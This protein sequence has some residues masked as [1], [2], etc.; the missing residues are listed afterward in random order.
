MSAFGP[1]RGVTEVP[2]SDFGLSGLFLI[3]G[4]TGAGK[5]TI[6]DAIS[7]A[8]YGNASGDNRTTDT[9]RSDYAKDDE[10][11]Y[12]ELSFSHHQK[13]YNIKRNPS[14]RRNKLRGTGTTEEKNN[15][16][17]TMPDGR[18]IC[19]YYPVTE[20]VIELLGIDWRQYK[21]IAMIAQ[22]EFLQLLNANSDERGVIFRKVFS[23]QVYDVIQKKLKEKSNQLK[24]QCEDIDKGILQYLNGILCKEDSVHYEA[25]TS[26]KAANSINQVE[27][28]MNL[29][30]TLIEKDQL[31]LADKKN[32]NKQLKQSIG[33]KAVEY[34][35]AEQINLKLINLNQAK[36]KY[37]QIMQN[38]EE[39]QL[40]EKKYIQAEKALY[41]VKPS[42]D[43]YLRLEKE[44]KILASD[45]ERG[46]A[47]ITQ[48]NENLLVLSQ[49]YEH[50]KES[51]PQIAQL[52]QEISR[53]E[54]ELLKYDSVIKEENRKSI[55]E[56]QIQKITLLMDR[57]ISQ[58][59]KLLEEQ[60]EKQEMMEKYS[61]SEKDLLICSNQLEV[62][63]NTITQNNKLMEDLRNI[64]TDYRLFHELQEEYLQAERNYK[65]TNSTYL[66]KE[67]LFL[68]E[69]AGI[70]ASTLEEGQPCPV[71]GSKD[72]PQKALLTVKAPS[73][74][75]LKTEKSKQ[76]KMH[77]NM[78][79]ASNRCESQ[80]TKIQLLQ[81]GIVEKAL[82]ILGIEI[83]SV[84]DEMQSLIFVTQDRLKETMV[85]SEELKKKYLQLQKDIENRKLSSERLL[86]IANELLGL[87]EK[88]SENT[89]VIQ[90]TKNELS[91]V[92]GTLFTIK[93][94]LK[95]S[96]KAEAEA[97]L[98]TIDAEC[99]KLQN[100]LTRAEA[101][102]RKCEYNLGNAN[103]VLVDNEKRYGI[104][105]IDFNMAKGHY[106]QKLTTYGFSDELD[107]RAVLISENALHNIKKNIDLFK[108][109]KETL[110][111]QIEQLKNETKDQARID[112]EKITQ[113][114]QKL[115][116]LNTDCEEQ[117]NMIYSRLTNN[118][119]IMHKV[120]EQNI[121]QQKVRQ[122]F[123]TI[124]E[125]SKTANGELSGKTKIAFEQYVQAFYF[126]KVIHE[127][128]KRFYHMSN[129]QY[130]LKRREDPSNLKSSS[131][132][133]LE[134]M[135]YYTGKS[136]SIKSLSGGESFK[137][138]LS[139]A[140]GLSDIIQSYAGGIEMNAMFVD[141]GFGSL[142]SDSLEQAIETL[143]DLT[144]GN[145][146][147]GIISH[148]NELK[149]RIDK[150]IL[151]EKSMEGS[152]LKLIK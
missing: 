29:L 5:T 100:D 102:F 117:I 48:L 128:N 99:K 71:C 139:L 109:D 66:G 101:S 119:D 116:Q 34:L 88:L 56:E 141:E 97:A 138:A 142:D 118:K 49:N 110:E 30:A 112:L 90:K 1:F 81:E 61:D 15:A 95:Y 12:V 84:K 39:M 120:E 40:E 122:E 77:N 114:Q 91:S 38:T 144:S 145:R 115:N 27:K 121:V 152:K 149:E 28:M 51:M 55:L 89:E 13:M 18:I 150:K 2:F 72:H 76:D 105:L 16:T 17:L 126:E 104:K 53:H 143:N 108:K 8:L 25:V 103:A 113:E 63:N 93:K 47:E 58:K 68:R 9:F 129:H 7:F 42:E 134:V 65:E 147:V 87:D 44:L 4:D 75:E 19:G 62:T 32:E 37:Q 83:Q 135:D 41:F 43:T 45:V 80:A 67:A 11:T 24:Y 127:A 86:K 21:Q 59:T 82:T 69:Q 92:E 79:K 22:G 132:L 148:V 96:T 130:A 6:F 94:D 78:M 124:S 54:A 74:E 31:E 106:Q 111:N 64:A 98:S 136:R 23:T 131:G 57:I 70:I 137:A 125:L 140:L 35:K 46:K 133:E 60:S 50:K 123:L 3:N 85:L 146:I 26:G 14:Y 36:I 33:E 73:A 52:L 10:E 107:Y 20:A 151:I